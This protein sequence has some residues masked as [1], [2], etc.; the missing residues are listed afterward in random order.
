MNVRDIFKR[1]PTQRDIPLEAKRA[2]VRKTIMELVS[3]AS[4]IDGVLVLYL[5]D[6]KINV[7]QG[8]LNDDFEAGVFLC[9]AEYLINRSGLVDD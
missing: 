6:G 4:E 5:H 3:V 1:Q 7:V 2:E 8:G 9:R